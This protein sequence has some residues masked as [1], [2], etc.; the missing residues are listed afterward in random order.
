MGQDQAPV[1]SVQGAK[2]AA[3][4]PASSRPRTTRG[5]IPWTYFALWFDGPIGA[6]AHLLSISLLA[7]CLGLS[8]RFTSTKSAWTLPFMAGG[9]F[10]TCV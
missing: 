8:N 10:M 9:T 7:S 5:W 3:A 4:W 6:M 1:P 2:G